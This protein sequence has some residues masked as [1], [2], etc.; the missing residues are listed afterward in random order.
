MRS[1]LVLCALCGVALAGSQDKVL[2]TTD[3]CNWSYGIDDVAPTLVS[4]KGTVDERH[5]ADGGIW[6]FRE[7]RFV[8]ATY[9]D[10]TGDGAEDALLVFEVTEQ[11]V[12]RAAGAPSTYAELWL[13]Q[14]RSDGIYKFTNESADAMP[15]KVAIAD[16]TAVLQWRVHGKTCEERWK[17][18]AEGEM[19]VKTQRRCK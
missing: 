5:S 17:F 1:L 19:A 11:P 2:R 7:F 6:A 3:W 12:L 8:S 18:Q 15:A 10:L 16:G 4:C 13:M 9:G 14:R